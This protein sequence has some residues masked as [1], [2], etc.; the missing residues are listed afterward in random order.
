[1]YGWVWG[2]VEF[3]FWGGHLP[4]PLLRGRAGRYGSVLAWPPASPRQLGSEGA[5]RPARAPGP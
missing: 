5:G 2:L 1:M 4:V 3:F